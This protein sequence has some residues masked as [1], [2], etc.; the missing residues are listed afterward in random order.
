MSFGGVPCLI[1][2]NT[3]IKVEGKKAIITCDCP[4]SEP[5]VSEDLVVVKMAE[6]ILA[7]GHKSGSFDPDV[8]N[9]WY[10]KALVTSI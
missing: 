4:G 9:E 1:C 6:K 2:A 7:N 10:A 5:I 3:Y 8:L